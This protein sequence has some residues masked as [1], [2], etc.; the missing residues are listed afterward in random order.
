MKPASIAANGAVN[1]NEADKEGKIALHKKTEW[2]KC[3][4]PSPHSAVVMTPAI[5]R[6]IIV[7]KFKLFFEKKT[8]FLGGADPFTNES[9]FRGE[10]EKRSVC[11]YLIPM[12]V[13]TC[14]DLALLVN[15]TLREYVAW[16][17]RA[18]RKKNS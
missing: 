13:G 11:C 15:E 17:S 10:K 7:I 8:T 4:R 2:N 1:W 6:Y 3:R 18:K 14:R 12:S 16:N 5:V 9:T